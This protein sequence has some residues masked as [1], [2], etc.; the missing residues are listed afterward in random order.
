[1][2]AVR[3]ALFFIVCAAPGILLAQAD[4]SG[5]RAPVRGDSAAARSFGC[6]CVTSEP[7]QAAVFL[8]DRAAGR[9]PLTLTAPASD[10]LTVLVVRQFCEPWKT[11]VTLRG[12]DTL[13]ITALLRRIETQVSV[14]AADS[15]S[16]VIVDGRRESTGSLF[17]F[18]ISPGYHSIRVDEPGSGRSVSRRILMGESQQQTYEAR[19][20]YRS[21]WRL[22]ASALVPG[23]SQFMDG[24]Y[25]EGA[26]ILASNSVAAIYALGCARTYSDRLGG[27]ATA[28]AD[29][30]GALTEQDAAA[31][32]QIAIARQDDANSAYRARNVAY[33]ILGAAYA[34]NIVETI[35]N[36]MLSDEI[37]FVP[38]EDESRFVAALQTPAFVMRAE[39]VIR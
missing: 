10:S 25:L 26:G 20:G 7:S 36:H 19:L 34:L 38:G 28:L 31:R 3:S 6:L 14:V 33:V 30:R 24:A 13:R 37:R 18:T 11:T 23:L 39:L 22:G 27:Y 15:T 35:L 5:A 17:R 12:G 32:R 21:F 8:G 9:T 2:T 16:R 1:M 29:Y 4:T